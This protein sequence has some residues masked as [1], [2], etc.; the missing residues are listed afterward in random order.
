MSGSVTLIIAGMLMIGILGAVSYFSNNMTLN[1]IK[2]K[3]VGDGQHGTAR[4]ATSKE[5]MRI[6]QHVPFTPQKWRGQGKEGQ[7]PTVGDKPVPQGIVVGC[8]GK[9]SVTAIVDTGD[10]HV[11]MIGAAGVGKTASGMSFLSTDT[12]GDVMRNYG[13]IA[14]NYYG[15]NVSV[16]DLRNPTRSN[17]NNLLHLVNRYMDLFKANPDKLVYKAKCEKYAK[18]IAK[19]IIL[20]GS[21]ASSFGA[22]AY[23]YDSAEGLLTATI[24]LVAEFCEPS[25]G[26][27]CR[28]SRLFRNCLRLPERK[29]RTSFSSSCSFFPMTTRRNGSLEPRSIRRSSRWLLLCQRHCQ[30]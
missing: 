3:T 6:Y 20:S 10:V 12:K 23:F 8:T 29:A 4:W 18:I 25:K 26:I 19:T 15:Y 30:G 2:S 11:L 14:K 28:C 17:G 16:I 22:N 5:I 21:D 7:T 24:L 1:N 27:L 13:T 9:K